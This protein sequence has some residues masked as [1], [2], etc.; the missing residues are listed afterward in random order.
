MNKSVFALAV[1]LAVSA[2]PHALATKQSGSPKSRE[3][4]GRS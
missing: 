4:L 2:A 1:A 3:S